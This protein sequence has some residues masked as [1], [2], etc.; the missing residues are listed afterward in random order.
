MRFQYK[1]LLLLL[2][3]ICLAI[4]GHVIF[5]YNYLTDLRYDVLNEEGKVVGAVQY[6]NNLIPVLV[7][8]V[9]SF[10]EHEDNVFNRT[11]DARERVLTMNK[12][13]ADK[14]RETTT[15]PVQGVLQRIMA[16]GEQYPLIR[17]SE[18]YQ[19]LMTQVAEAEAKILVQRFE[20]NDVVN[21]YTTAMSMF[22][23]NIYAT[24]FKF[25]SYEYF[26]GSQGSEWPQVRISR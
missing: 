16:I 2:A 14:L 12:R 15:E 9:A 24:L 3:L 4:C 6:R 21:L 11:V 18:P 25:P 22:P 7:E 10:V 8:S 26:T 20:Y 17:T 1:I 5:Y 23:G 13:V 19:V